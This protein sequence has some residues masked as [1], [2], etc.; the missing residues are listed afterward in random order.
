MPD[1]GG[2]GPSGPR[3]RVGA[4]SRRSR[5]LLLTAGVLA[6]LALLFA[7]FAGFWTDWLWYRSLHYSSVFTTRLWTKTGLFAV[8]GLLMALTVGLNIWLAHRLRPPL[9]AMSPEQQGLD[10]YRMGVAPYRRWVLLGAS[11][12]TG[13]IAGAA[14]TGRWR[15]W[16][17][18]VNGTSFGTRDPQFHK[19]VSF[20]AFDLP[21]YRFL[22]DFGFSAVVVALLAAV[23]VHYLYGGLR[24]QG[25]GRRVSTAAQGHLAVLLGVFVAL[26]AVAYWL[27]RYG[28]AL[29][30]GAIRGT[31]SWTGLR[32]VDANAYLPAKTILCCVAVICA[33]LFLVTPLRRTWTLPLV[34][35]GLMVLSALLIGGLY[36][37]I[38][39]Q[40]QVKPNEASKEAPYIRKNIDATRAA[41]GIDGTRVQQYR[42]AVDPDRAALDKDTATLGN[43]R[44]LDPN[45]VSPTFT[46]R[47][48]QRSYYS[49]ASPLDID[50]YGSGAGVQDTVIGLR[51]LNLAGV[52]SRNWVNDHFKYTHGYA[53]VTAK[54]NTV[55][56]DGDPVFTE[57]GLPPR[58]QFP[59]DT[60]WRV[61]FG[62]RTTAYSVVGGSNKELDYYDRDAGKEVTYTYDG[63]GGVSLDNPLTRAAYAVKFSEPQL[64]YSGAITPGA[65]ILY[66]RTPKERVEAVAPWL[67]IDGDPYP[68]V[69]GGKV[70]WVV[71]GY[72]TSNGYPYA[73]R[74]TLG[75]VTADSLTADGR[76]VLA[77]ADRVN[78]IRNSVKA[79]VD[80]FTGEVT[81]YQ[82]DERDPV[83]RTWMKS[84][85]GTVK[86][87]SA[88]DPALMQHLRYPQDL[89]KVQRD[90]L[91]RYHVTD[92]AAFYAGSDVWKVPT[93]P[94]RENRADQPPYYLTVRMPGEQAAF[95]LT[96]SFVPSSRQNL[97]AFMAVNANPGPDYGRMHILT[98]P[99]RSGDQ[100]VRG[101]QQVQAKFN[102]DPRIAYDINLLKQGD[103]SLEYG[104]LLTLPV[105]DGLLYVEPV[106]VRGKNINY[107]QL[108]KVL[109]VYGGSDNVAYADTL[110]EALQQVLKV[111]AGTVP[112]PGGT[113]PPSG[114]TPTAPGSPTGPAGPANPAVQKA[115]DDAQAAF[116]AGQEALRK[117]D[118]A[119]YGEQQKKLR[120]A[121]DAAVK[122]QRPS[123]S[124]SPA[125][126]G[127]PSPAPSGAP[128][129]APSPTP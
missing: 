110:K 62:E 23:L 21:W 1:R 85:P 126:S 112:E 25:P 124:P 58:G 89:F 82:W 108:K 99:E 8:F 57:S 119:A 9:S 28:L 72:T 105:G 64:L 79:T 87:R 7:V 84:F 27:D 32:Y 46:Q 111:D 53:A 94:T 65:R 103:S 54:G 98:M 29:K 104:N 22:L 47:E 14:A 78:Y 127:S 18:W 43:I 76:Q 71:D 121:L 2:A 17:Q 59:A 40:F 11:V 52:P 116:Q 3:F 36:P 49:F 26:K 122:A 106:Y 34:G 113:A 19:D 50:R 24:L 33:L 4:S 55:G 93:D 91:T 117:G 95:S 81:L 67:S 77:Q 80:A 96:T 75:D 38:V 129:P 70:K 109:A 123:G 61:Y 42:A 100:A 92:P 30:S 83:L 56:P 51:E 16:L 39:Q 66:D 35:F 10:R 107:P 63:G 13:L 6:V 125:P 102:S 69:V 120:D 73:S 12:V 115:L 101:P 118:W 5:A 44:V 90:L 41:Y 45:I 114:G 86:P 15:T 128:S 68:V 48:Q 74:T 20:Y 37:A 88:I 97:A 60:R 31:D